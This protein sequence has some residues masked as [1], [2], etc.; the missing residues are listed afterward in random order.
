MQRR[1]YHLRKLLNLPLQSTSSASSLLFKLLYII[2]NLSV[3]FK[4]PS[5][6]R[7]ECLLC[8]PAGS[9]SPINKSQQYGA[10]ACLRMSLDRECKLL[11]FHRE[12]IP[13]GTRIRPLQ[14]GAD[15][16]I[17]AGLGANRERESSNA[18]ITCRKLVSSLLFDGSYAT[19]DLRWVFFFTVPPRPPHPVCFGE[20]V[21]SF[22]SLFWLFRWR[23]EHPRIGAEK[24]C[25][26]WEKECWWRFLKCL[27]REWE[28]SV[29]WDTI[30]PLAG[31][32]R[33]LSTVACGINSDLYS[34]QVCVS[35]SRSTWQISNI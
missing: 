20:N 19:I 12:E 22:L 13:A 23:H 2:I 8:S 33:K 32:C 25:L 3:I 28:A 1:Y 7:S 21:C 31:S 26:W 30:R 35:Q 29:Q 9:I 16:F 4:S 27:G 6:V 18:D 17:T 34:R 10:V 5:Q 15:Q 14:W 11:F 24:N